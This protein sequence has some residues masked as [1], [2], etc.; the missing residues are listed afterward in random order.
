MLDDETLQTALCEVEAILIDHPITSSS[1]E[2]ND[3]KALTPKPLIQLKVKPICLYMTCISAEEESKC[4]TLQICFGK[5]GSRNTM[6][7][8]GQSFDLVLGMDFISPRSLCLMGRI[9]ETMA[10]SKGFVHLVR[11]RT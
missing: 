1:D 5:G 9:I 10:D 3:L 7:R 2:P 11:F 6:M 8:E 4:N